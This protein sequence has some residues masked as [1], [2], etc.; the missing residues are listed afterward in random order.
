MESSW[1]IWSPLLSPPLLFGV[2]ALW[3]VLCFLVIVVAVAVDCCRPS[4]GC[5]LAKEPRMC[6]LHVWLMFSARWQYG[7]LSMRIVLSEETAEV[8]LSTCDAWVVFVEV[9]VDLVTV[10]LEEIWEKKRSVKKK[11]MYEH[12]N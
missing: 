12:K 7:D 10:D 3:R 5:N 1:S 4:V 9:L 2:V 6:F 8:S 11:F